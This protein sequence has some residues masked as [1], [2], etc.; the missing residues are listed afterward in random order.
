MYSVRTPFSPCITD[1]AQSASV[2][3]NVQSS[4][5]KNHF[6]PP[7]SVIRAIFAFSI[8]RIASTA[9]LLAKLTKAAFSGTNARNGP[10]L[11]HP[12]VAAVVTSSRNHRDDVAEPLC[13]QLPYVIFLSICVNRPVQAVAPANVVVCP[14]SK[15]SQIHTTPPLTKVGLKKGPHKACRHSADRCTHQLI[16]TTFPAVWSER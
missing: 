2:A 16:P 1:V 11:A 13:W 6:V 12:P 5:K 7:L 8:E 15:S 14:S 4:F 10:R 3:V 9:P